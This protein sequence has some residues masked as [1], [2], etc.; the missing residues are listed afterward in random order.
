M[1][2]P[3][4]WLACAAAYAVLGALLAQS[5]RRSANQ[6]ALAAACTLTALWAG[7]QPLPGLRGGAWP[8][9][10]DALRLGSWLVFLALAARA[11]GSRLAW[12]PRTTA[13]AALLA[14]G[15]A[16]LVAH[17]VWFGAPQV[18]EPLGLLVP[19]GHLGLAI[20]GLV[21]V[22]AVLSRAR[23][24]GHHR[25]RFLALGIGAVLAYEAFEWSQALLYDQLDP[26]LRAAE[27]GVSL[28]AAPL[29]ALGAARNQLWATELNLAR[30]AV[31]HSAT[32]FAMAAYLL[33]L[34][35]A[36]V[37][38]RQS[39]GLWGPALQVVFL[40]AGV[41][42]LAL[43]WASPS[44]RSALRFRLGSYLFTHRHDYREQWERFATALAG[45]EQAAS[46]ASPALRALADV[47]GSLWGALWLRDRDSFLLAASLGAP[48]AAIEQQAEGD[49]TAWIESRGGAVSELA[50]APGLPAKLDWGWIVVPL[51]RQRLV[52][53]AVL[54][55]PR[56]RRSLHAEDAEL[57]RIAGVHAASSL[58]ADQRA[59]RLAEVQRF[60]E[61]SRGLA[62]VAHDLRNVAN[63]LTLTL[64]NA[65]RHIGRPEFQRDLILS[66]EDSVRSMQ[67][68][69]DK[70]ARRRRDAAV[71]EPVDLGPMVVATVRTR[72][73]AAA[74]LALEHEP[75]EVLPIAADP[76]RLAAMSGHLVQNALDA[77]GASGHVVVRLRRAGAHA[78]LEVED[79]G[80]GMPPE[81]L[82]D[83]L[84]H[85]FQSSK[86]DGFG[87]G[88]F[89]CSELARELGG[90]LAVESA[91]GRGTAARLRLPLA[92]AGAEGERSHG[93]RA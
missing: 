6:A 29:L 41:L 26:V 45:S 75:S 60:E 63:E 53:Y 50:G 28:L 52:G 35:L 78:L 89:E 38:V 59:R 69:L 32:L 24:A 4:L 2:T 84:R 18:A 65:R 8:E 55:R 68:L 12:S 22:E 74:Q 71:A 80:P 64:A 16:A 1:L 27:P 61:V 76:E 92:T 36:G 42:L 19:S 58:L 51:V 40:F 17:A 34:A 14:L 11:G 81:L 57:L 30:R 79:D 85:P 48:A 5:P 39:G 10:L 86:P 47:T 88:L 46:A 7:V 54:S 90:E 62:F 93:R 15:I 82:R 67:R 72:R 87:L 37:L 9:L 91:P 66:M 73:G 23:N 21:L 49:F 31:I 33:G 3:A 56:A 20:A 70:V 13:L 44:A 43:V 77:A 25:T 83:R